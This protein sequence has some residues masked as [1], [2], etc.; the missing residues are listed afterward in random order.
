MR[1]RSSGGNQP[2]NEFNEA[3]EAAARNA[4]EEDEQDCSSPSQMEE[5]GTSDPSHGRLGVSSGGGLPPA[6]A[7]CLVDDDLERDGTGITNHKTEISKKR[8]HVIE[9][10][11]DG[12]DHADDSETPV[13]KP[14]T[15]QSTCE[16]THT[17]AD[18]AKKRESGCKKAEYSAT[19]VDEFGNRWRLIVYVNGN[20][21]A[22][23]HH[24][25]LFLQV[26]DAEELPFGW[27][28]AVSYVLTL[29]HPNG[30]NLGY[31][32]RNPDKTFKLCPKAI[33][34]GWSQFITS[35]RIQQEG[36]VSDDSLTVRASVSVKSSSVSIDSEDA[37]L[38]LKC[39]VEEGNRD[40]VQACLDQGAG[41][42]CQFKDDLYTPLH[43]ACSSTASIGSLEV[44]NLLLAKDADGNACNKWRETP[45][46][47]AANNGHQAAVEALLKHGADPSLCSEAGWSALT[48]AA[49]KGYDDIVTLLLKAEAPVNCRVTEDLSTPLHKA[50]AGSKP[51]HL[52]A[53]KQLL[54]NGADVHALNKWRE[55]PLLTAANHGQAAAVEALLRAG[56]DPCKCTDTG[57][58]PLSIAAYKGHDDVVRLLLEEGAPTEEADPTLSALLQA[59]TKGL[60]ETVELLLRH[61]ADHTVTTKKGDTALSILVEQN[62]IDAAVEMVTEYKASVPRCSRDRK[63]VQRARLLINLRVKQQQREGLLNISTDDETDD[64]PEESNLA[65]HEVKNGSPLALI[66]GEGRQG[67]R[68]KKK[69][70]NS[71]ESAEAQARAAEEALLLE[72]EQ[73]ESQ[74]QKEEAVASTKR[75]KNKKKK[76]RQRLIKVKEEQEQK[77]K[78]D[79]ATE[80][81]DRQRQ[82]REEKEKMEREQRLLEQEMKEMAEREKL[83]KEQA[84]KRKEKEEKERRQRELERKREQLQKKFMKEFKSVSPS[85][86]EKRGKNG[87]QKNGVH[88]S[89][90]QQTMIITPGTSS[91]AEVGGHKRGWEMKTPNGPSLPETFQPATTVNPRSITVNSDGIVRHQPAVS[92][93]EDHME[94]MASGMVDFL[95][96]DQ[97]QSVH[98]D[99]Q[100]S[101]SYLSPTRQGT[102]NGQHFATQVLDN[103]YSMPINGLSTHQT[104]DSYDLPHVALFRQEKLAELV[105]RCE[106]ARKQGGVDPLGVVDESIL[107]TVLYRWI[108]RAAHTKTPFLDYLIPSWTD[109]EFLSTF[110]QRQFIAESRKCSS[111]PTAGVV[112]ME[113]LKEAGAAFSVLCYSL[114]QDVV[115]YK[116]ETESRLP[117]DW[118]DATLSLTAS[119]VMRNGMGS[120]VC[121]DWQNRAQIYMTTTSFSKLRE[122][123]IGRS[124]RL[125]TALFAAKKRYDIT[126]MLTAGTNMDLR[127]TPATLRSMIL[128]AGVCA[129]LWTTPFSV[130]GKE[131]FFG[132]YPDVDS[133]FGGV[134]SFG[135]EDAGQELS[136]LSQSGSIVVMPPLD[137]MIA[138]HYVRRIVDFLEAGDKEG[139]PLSFLVILHSECF[140]DSSRPLIINDLAILEPRLSERHGAFLRCAEVLAAGHHVFQSGEGIGVST[141]NMT[142]SLF[143]LFQNDTG[144]ARI[145]IREASLVEIIRSMMPRVESPPIAPIS[146]SPF[147]DNYSEGYNSSDSFGHASLASIG[148]QGQRQTQSPMRS[149]VINQVDFGGIAG[150]STVGGQ[151]D[152]RRS[153]LF[154]LIDD[155][156]DEGNTA[157]V[158]MVSGMLN[159]LNILK[160]ST[161]QDLDV[162][163]ISLMGFGDVSLSGDSSLGGHAARTLGRFG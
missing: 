101:S 74:A 77:E 94:N 156:P 49:H 141:I 62:L 58:S 161:S 37:E 107:K 132:T 79:K 52:S 131:T 24:L 105:Q 106:L 95:G 160:S 57:W 116:R 61:G 4:P 87:I 14:Q 38:Y 54:Q 70:S 124:S 71:A 115:N 22:S 108:V 135:K 111:A 20:G 55:T 162:E 92:A 60:P 59:A 89:G 149:K 114:A 104:A 18:Y 6:D 148:Y 83:A 33:D 109:F 102:R 5:E 65:L 1:W 118:S 15:Q 112:R 48:F 121:V 78:E 130:V 145:P 96:F 127:L 99:T 35:D 120:M 157:D 152:S 23:N 134:P 73:E 113:A 151:H 7:T 119:E 88:H 9:D 100:P 144:K 53:V 159:N 158:D 26:A 133:P 51:G 123:F 154:D 138:A 150:A 93:V 68:K 84:V 40:A 12:A 13:W 147:S 153:R 75:A 16:F 81:R 63:K 19:T 28:K 85:G 64:E 21:R 117:L 143:A 25:S 76:E 110:L 50:C 2:Q 91:D 10:D 98:C 8:A 86:T 69:K 27:K 125:L 11:D 103:Q 82:A 128:H 122:R 41:V 17:I 126:R 39:A 142:G 43:T 97:Q 29:E 146:S 47:I 136:L 90:A 56:G 44:L 129:E 137:N 67:E 139:I 66:P 46:L 42:N 155:G 32:K 140:L 30:G 36:Y 3:E 163:A 31:A 34:W 72:L 80:E 45:L